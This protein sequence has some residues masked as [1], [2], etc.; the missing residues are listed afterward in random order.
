MTK[1]PAGKIV[2]VIPARLRS[3]RFP[4][5]ALVAINGLPMV[6]QVYSRVRKAAVLDSV[7]VAT[8]SQRVAAA[9]RALDI[10]VVMTSSSCRTGTDRVAEVARDGDGDIYVNVQ[11]DEPFIE[12]EVV[13]KAVMPFLFDDNLKMGTVATTL[14]N[15]KEWVDVNV[16][17]VRVTEDGFAKDFFRT[18]PERYLPPN[19]YKHIG[20]YVYEKE[21]LLEFARMR[22]TALER[23]RNLEQLRAMDHGVLIKVVLTDYGDFSIDTPED[24]KRVDEVLGGV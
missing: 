16:V 2:G 8:D 4:G 7:V 17:K 10:P 3:T 14:L 1:R 13:E 12:V 11:G 23:Q 18:S 15:R 6:A 19:T 22:R 5:K 9:M 24:L 20:L 21:F